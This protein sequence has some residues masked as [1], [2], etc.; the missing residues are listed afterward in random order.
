MGVSIKLGNKVY[1]IPDNIA[2]RA[3]IIQPDLPCGYT[4]KNEILS[5]F[6]DALDKNSI[7]APF[8][9]CIINGGPT[10]IVLSDKTR[11]YGVRAWLPRLL[12]RLNRLGVTNNK[13]KILF[14]TGTH[15]GHTEDEKRAVVG[16]DVAA[17]VEMIDHDCDDGDNLLHVGTTSLGTRVSINRHATD[18]ANLIITGVVMPHY[19]AGFSGG[20][21]SIM[22]GIAARETILANH[23]L[24]LAPGGGTRHEASTLKLAG[25]PIHCDMI[26]ALAFVDVSFGINVIMGT[27]G[28]PAEFHAGSPLR[29]HESACAN[30]RK[31]A[32]AKITQRADWVVASCGGHPC[33][34]NFYQ[35]HKS[36]DN[37][38]RAVRK[39]GTIV[40]FAE[41]T[42]GLG[43]PCFS[44]W[45]RMGGIGVIENALRNKYVVHGHTAMR[46]IEKTAAARVILVTSLPESDVQLTGA[47]K[48]ENADQAMS[49]IMELGG[50]GIIIPD[51]ANTV[52][53]PVGRI[54]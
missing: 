20:R 3:Q 10:C 8:D 43:P 11:K 19:Y 52:P 28:A 48:A 17:R 5:A 12:D 13:I 38:F 35:S 34:I 40:L 2:S 37:A 1:N 42:A 44:D 32:R 16:S 47:K 51:A 23:A 25:N 29:A 31:Y 4:D 7:G 21:K 45:F 33:D 6:D 22:P 53:L 39:G 27:G 30:M 41:C 36:L 24:N 49:E 9:N 14:A 26:E 18:A 15:Y 54:L 50:N 46:I